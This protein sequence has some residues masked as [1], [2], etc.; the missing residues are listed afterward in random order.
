MKIDAISLRKMKHNLVDEVVHYYLDDT[1]LNELLGKSLRVRFG[2]MITCIACGRAGLKKT[3]NQGY[4]YPCFRSLARCDSCII[5]PE[6]CHYHDGTCRE[7]EWGES[8]CLR[9]HVV[10][11]ANTSGIKVGV[12]GAHKLHERW[13][14]QGATEAVVIARVP[15][16]LLAGKIESVLKAAIP[17]KTNWRH[18]LTGVETPVDFVETF[19]QVKELLGEDLREYLLSEKEVEAGIQLL[20]YPVLEFLPKATT[21]NLDKVSEIEGRFSGIRGQYLFLGSKGLNIRKYQG[22]EIDL[23]VN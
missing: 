14:D 6:K 19:H 3:F 18:L 5:K 7:P 16:R 21:W 15:E 2:G 9:E 4:C 1:P 10:Y 11:L 23:E 12:T 20:R 17:D 8:H 22:Y 13:G